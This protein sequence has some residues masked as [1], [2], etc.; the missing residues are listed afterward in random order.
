VSAPGA[1]V[2][3]GGKAAEAVDPDFEPVTHRGLVFRSCMV[4]LHL[5]CRTVFPLRAFG[6]E[7]VAPS[8]GMLIACNHQSFLDIPF[9]AVA[10]SPRHVAFMARRSLEEHAAIRFLIR[11]CGAI[12]VDRGRADR[13]ALRRAAAHLRAGDLVAVYPEGTRTR[14]GRIAPFKR[15]AVLAARMA[16]VPILPCAIRGSFEAWPRTRRLP[17]PQRIEVRFGPPVDAAADDALERVEARV[18]EMYESA[19]G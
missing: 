1:P 15:G 6:L 10:V 8:G 18:R 16:S 5:L 7:H 2:D 11:T 17:R 19:A 12:P 14:D 4:P 3:E 9:V 13:A